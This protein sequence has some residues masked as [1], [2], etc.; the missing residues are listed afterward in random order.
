[1]NR[2]AKARRLLLLA[3]VV[4]FV[5]R[6]APSP[7][8]AGADQQALT[9]TKES[10]ISVNVDNEPLNALLRMM[11]D[12]KLFTLGGAAAGN[13]SLTLHFSNLTVPE[14]LSKILRGYN[15]VVTGQGNGRLPVL[16]VLGKVQSGGAAPHTQAPAPA[17]GP[18]EPRSYA[19]PEPAAAPET[20]QPAASRPPVASAQAPQDAAPPNEPARQAGQTAAA[21][22]GNQS[23]GQPGGEARRQAG[24][25][26]P[27]GQSA[28]PAD[29]PP[30]E[31]SGVHF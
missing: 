15:Y 9:V 26:A 14:A 12:K 13:E 17:V 2:C 23:S 25:Q 16:T 5:S 28:P 19:P 31:S 8:M 29:A 20:P 30:A 21:P 4:V 3:S 6:L 24:Q 10:R 27:E 18:P 22:A 1:M 7:A 11:A